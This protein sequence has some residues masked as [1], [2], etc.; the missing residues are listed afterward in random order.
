MLVR[1]Q[2]GKPTTIYFPVSQNLCHLHDIVSDAKLHYNFT[3]RHLSVFCDEG[4]SFLLVAFCGSGSWS[5]TARQIGDIPFAIIR[6]Y[7]IK[8]RIMLASM[9]KSP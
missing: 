2:S 6:K 5:T 3:N 8:R 1:Q 9:Q 4:I 7:F